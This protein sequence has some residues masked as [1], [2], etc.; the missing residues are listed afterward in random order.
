MVKQTVGIIKTK[1]ERADNLAAG[2]KFLGITESADDTIGTSISFYL[3]HAVA[4]ASLI[5][6]IE[7]LRNDAIAPAPSGRKPPFGVLQFPAGRRKT[8]QVFS[9]K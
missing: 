1:Q 6:K 9:E 2:L 5:W 4:V 8:K 3:L 7:T